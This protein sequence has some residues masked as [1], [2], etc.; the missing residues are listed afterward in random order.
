MLRLRLLAPALL[1]LRHAGSPGVHAQR[2]AP[3]PRWW[4]IG[5]GGGVSVP[6]SDAKDAWD[7]GVNGLA[8]FRVTPSG[9]G[10]TFGVNVTFS[11]LDFSDS[12]VTTSAPGVTSGTTEMLGGLGD[13]KVNV[14]HLGPVT[15]YITGGVGVYNLKTETGVTMLVQFGHRVR[16]QRR[17]RP[18]DRHQEHLDLRPGSSGQRVHQ[19]KPRHRQGRDPGRAGLG[20]H[21]V[22]RKGSAGRGLTPIRV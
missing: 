3:T 14:M 6:V 9:F 12:F 8:Y 22:L 5:V 10:I 18:V 21:R 7:N 4:H 19:R 20:G 1:G 2:N 13:M 16:N 17:S 11:T 15:P